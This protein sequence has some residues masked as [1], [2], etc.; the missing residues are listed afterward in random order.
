MDYENVFAAGRR[1]A[2]AHFVILSTPNG[3]G[4][5]RLG[6]AISRRHI[7]TAV[8]RNRVKRVVRES[9]RRHRPQLGGFDIVVMAQSRTGGANQQSLAESLARHWKK[10]APCDTSSS[11]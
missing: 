6:L 2:D 1:S 5:A 7:P 4:G 10:L 3:L 11:A 9:F 8:K